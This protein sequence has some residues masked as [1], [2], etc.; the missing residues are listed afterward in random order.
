MF[1][2]VGHYHSFDYGSKLNGK[3]PQV[4]ANDS[5][6]IYDH[7]HKVN[8]Y[9]YLWKFQWKSCL[10]CPRSN[11]CLQ[12]ATCL[13][14]RNTQVR[15]GHK[16]LGCPG[17]EDKIV[18]KAVVDSILSPIYEEHF[19]GYSYGFR[20]GRGA[21]N[22]LDALAYGI[23]RRKISYILDADIKSYFD[24]VDRKTLIRFLKHLIGDERLIRLFEKWL[25]CGVLSQGV[26]EDTGRGTVQGSNISPIFAN[27]YLH[28]VLDLWMQKWRKDHATGDMIFVRYAD[29]FVV[30]FQYKG[31]AER[32]LNDLK[33]RLKEFSLEIHPGKTRLIEFGRFANANCR[34][35]GLGHSETFD[36]LGFT[37]FCVRTRKGGFRIGRKPI[38]KR[39]CRTLQHLKLS[40]RKRVY[41]RDLAECAKWLGLVIKGWLNYFAVPGSTV[42]LRKFICAIRSA[43]M[44][45]IRRRSQRGRRFSWKRLD[46]MIR[47]FWPRISI[48]HPW[49]TDRFAMRYHLK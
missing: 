3:N 14:G 12:R 44:K 21:H 48:R 38:S 5:E 28:Y 32:F 23:E 17:L 37:H 34:R 13:A 46:R 20:P 40:L 31:E 45:A 39:V 36:F 8:D 49:P 1:C 25:K 19:L 22:A 47:L 33:R 6:H 2:L 29:D 16:T 43:W 41:T 7:L 27:I 24:S 15:R 4:D 9:I 10:L 26:L 30:G 11:G 18:Q 42:Y 35:R